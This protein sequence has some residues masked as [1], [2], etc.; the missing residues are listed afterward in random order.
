[1]KMSILDRVLL[2]VTG[3]LAAYQIAFVIDDF[4][5][6]P[7]I[8]YTIAFGVLLVAGLLIII[9]GFEILD[10]PVVVIVS[11]IIPLMLSL[12]TRLA[13][14]CNIQDSIPDL[15]H[16]WIFSHR[17]HALISNAVKTSDNRAC[18][19]SRRR[20]HD[21]LP[22]AHNFINAGADK[23]AFL[24]GRYRR[25]VDRGR[26]SFALISQSRQAHPVP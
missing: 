19:R 10:N 25:R 17:H 12:G 3:L 4:S 2:L 1:M 14:P 18:H 13:A 21:D 8:T 11:T 15:C 6:L 5:A 24:A 20:R 22:A 26:W 7:L 9:L 16:H 23:S